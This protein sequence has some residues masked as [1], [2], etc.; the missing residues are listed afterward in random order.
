M[1]RALA[2]L[3]LL[4]LLSALGSPLPAQSRAPGGASALQV[5]LITFGEGELYWEK[6]GHNALWFRDT[7]QGIDEA[8]NWGM[9]D[10]AGP[11][12]L[13]RQIIGDPRYWV[14]AASGIRL[15][16]AYQQRDR[17]VVIQRLNLTLAQAQKALQL[18][19]TNALEANK[20]YRYD[21]FRDNCSTRV[22]DMIDAAL[23]G[24]LKAATTGAAGRRTYRS[25]TLRLVDDL[26]LTQFGIDV[27][28]G[29]PAD[30][31]LSVWE[32]AFVPSRLR[33]A[34]RDVRVRSDSAGAPAPFVL[35]ER[36]LHQSRSHFERE[37]TPSLWPAYLT[38]GLV[39][40]VLLVAI[41][42]AAVKSRRRGVE[43]IL[44]FDIAVWSLI[45]GVLGLIVSL[46]WLITEHVFWYRNDN[47]LLL[48]P[49]SLFVAVLA[50]LSVWKPRYTRA[51]AIL[52]VIALMAS[53]IAIIS[54]AIPP[55][56]QDNLP[57]ILLILPLHLAI[58]HALWR[59]AM[60]L[61][62]P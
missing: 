19:R 49:L 13:R 30:Q 21:Y 62:R 11:G 56:R 60:A 5:W 23:D 15:I 29:R 9:F 37:T 6:Y 53:A 50:P 27:A 35:E 36:T 2:A 48:N 26:K 22:R 7:T 45:A 3:A 33:D 34:L 14:E 17:S 61:P 51:A 54:Y 10:F 58:A 28:L 8:Y 24:G 52:A 41:D 44:R 12:F 39:L 43:T 59:R 4:V 40:A 18:S 1:R 32:N 42:A 20:F 46:A 25:E 31:P 38:I 57:L 55:L 16:D 47:L